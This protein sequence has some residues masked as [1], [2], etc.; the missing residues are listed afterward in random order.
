MITSSSGTP[1]HASPQE[2]S[3]QAEIHSEA[4]LHR[5]MRDQLKLSVS[6]A[7]SFLVALLGLPL[8]NYF[9]PEQM[10]KDVGGFTVTWLLLGVLFFPLVWVV[11]FVFIKRSIKMEEAEV[12][13]V[14][15]K[16]SLTRG[17]L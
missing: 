14:T 6:C 1:A 2:A 3:M 7:V 11:A 12:N 9:Y 13:S 5:L 4:F 8:L 10:N 17:S 15:S 16:T